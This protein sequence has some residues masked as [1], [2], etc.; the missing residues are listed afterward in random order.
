MVLKAF[1]GDGKSS[2]LAIRSALQYAVDQK[3]DVVNM[4]FGWTGMLWAYSSYLKDV[5]KKAETAGTVVCCAAG[6]K[7]SDVAMTYPA[8]KE[9]VITVSAIRNNGMFA[10]DYSNYGDMIDFAAPGTAVVSTY[11]GGGKKSM[12]GTSMATPHVV[13]AIAYIKM[14]EPKLNYKGVKNRLKQYAEDRGTLGWDEK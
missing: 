7:A 12:S 11:L 2:N 13:A 6:N 10:S 1:D 9:N 3:A 14:I 8:N 4:S 5:L